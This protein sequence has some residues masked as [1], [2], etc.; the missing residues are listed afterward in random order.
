MTIAPNNREAT[1]ASFSAYLS[2]LR[3][4]RGYGEAL[5]AKGA[6]AEPSQTCR[7]HV[8]VFVARSTNCMYS[9][10]ELFLAGLA[11]DAFSVMRT[12]CELTMD[13]AYILKEDTIRRFELFFG[14][15]HLVN[16]RQAQFIHRLHGSQ[17]SE[18]YEEL[19]SRRDEV[20][21]DYGDSFSWAGVKLWTRAEEAGLK[22]MYRSIYAEGCSAVHS[23]PATM[24]SA[25]ESV[26]G[27]LELLI[28]PR[29]PDSSRV[30]DLATFCHAQLLMHA[31]TY[32]EWLD[33]AQQIEDELLPRLAALPEQ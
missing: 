29:T 1:E 3:D 27:S 6:E 20:A 21:P 30:L 12:V 22:E 31:A 33:E 5:I 14:F 25:Y 2:L 9:I 19:R 17:E 28:G 7:A 4:V 26:D 18:A 24:R 23:G 10:E 15:E 11:P 13:L 8:M 16:M 32:C